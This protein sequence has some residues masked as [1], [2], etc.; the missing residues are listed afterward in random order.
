[1]R[2]VWVVPSV[3][4]IATAL[5]LTHPGRAVADRFLSSLRIEKPKTVAAVFSAPSGSSRRVED[6]VA[7]MLSD[8]LS[9]LS[10]E[11]DRSVAGLQEAA[12]A[13]G[14]TPSLPSARTD[15]PT[16]EVTG[17]STVSM[18]VNRS[19]L[20]TIL[21]E[22]GA[23]VDLPASVN[24]TVVT[25]KT[26]RG[27]RVQYGHCP[28][29]P[30]TTLQGQLVGR[31]PDRSGYQDCVILT[32]TPSVVTQAP[33]G[34]DTDQLVRI[35]L[36]VSGLSPDEAGAFQGAF[37]WKTSLGLAVP[38]FMRSMKPV[39]LH[40]AEGMLMTSGWRRGPRYVLVWAA[41]GRVYSLSGYGDPA[42]AVPLATSMG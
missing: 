42:D 18:A 27:V 34:L 25:V 30:D 21:T 35:A 16:F 37:D 41:G 7:R 20:A 6:L 22:A 19:Q 13:A 40:G 26:P 31:P 29:P 9:V 11:P 12:R 32:E 23:S 8:S 3:I 15:A 24:G 14:F 17:A 28:P 4:V 2:P 33:P 39:D 5:L 1:M 38:R 36:E 10:A